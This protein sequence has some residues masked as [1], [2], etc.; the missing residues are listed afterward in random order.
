VLGLSIERGRRLRVGIVGN[1]VIFYY[2][3]SPEEKDA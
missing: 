1:K 3:D 2:D